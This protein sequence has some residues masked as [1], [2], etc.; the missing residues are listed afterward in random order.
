MGEVVEHEE[1]EGDRGYKLTHTHTNR[2]VLVGPKHQLDKVAGKDPS[3]EV[4]QKDRRI[5]DPIYLEG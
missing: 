1:H 3:V 5:E 4:P 2:F